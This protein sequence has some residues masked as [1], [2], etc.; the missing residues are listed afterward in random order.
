MLLPITLDQDWRNILR[1]AWSVR[2][3]IVAALLDGL[4]TALGIDPYLIPWV[5]DALVAGLAGL[6]SAAALFSRFIA[7]KEFLK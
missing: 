7:Q 6:A 1:H 4:S 2:L 3:L 5:P